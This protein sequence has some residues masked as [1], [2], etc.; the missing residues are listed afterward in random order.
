MTEPVKQ[1]MEKN[2]ILFVRVPANMKNIFQPLDLTV[3]GS[4][5]SLMKKKNLP[6]G[7]AKK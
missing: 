1:K 5:K 3:N 2:Y 4:F 7:I 6:N